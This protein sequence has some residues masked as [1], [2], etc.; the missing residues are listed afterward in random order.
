[1][2]VLLDT[3]VLSEIQHPDGHPAVIRTVTGF[4]DRDIF[5]SI[6]SVGEIA[7]GIAL[8]DSPRRR[9]E[10]SLW[11]NGLRQNYADRLLPVDAP[12]AQL[13]GELSAKTQK[14]GHQTG[15]ADG[16]IAATAIVHGLYVV[17]RN[18]S[19]FAPTGAMILN[20]WEA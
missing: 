9:Q 5:L 7:R 19:D 16:L 15:M 13:W 18:V 12:V 2:K 8:L 3:C 11:L 14:E 4:A 10:L 1:M 20:P 6:I 17:T